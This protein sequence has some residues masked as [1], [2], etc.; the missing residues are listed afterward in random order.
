MGNLSDEPG[1]PHK[2]WTCIDILDLRPDARPDS[3]EQAPESFYETCEMCGQERIRYL[4]VMEHAE[5]RDSLRVGC[6][7]AGKMSGDYE[8]ARQRE[9]TARNRA[10]RKANWLRRKWRTSAKGNPY[11]NLNGHNIGVLPSRLRA[12]RWCF[13]VDRAFSSRNYASEEEAKLAL[14]DRICEIDAQ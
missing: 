14:F 1:V 8:G 12:D 2:G 9:K 4:H 10:M 13:F 6:V 7:C 3:R 11:L 5:Y